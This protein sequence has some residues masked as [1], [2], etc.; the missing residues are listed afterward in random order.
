MIPLSLSSFYSLNPPQDLFSPL[1]D[2]LKNICA[3]FL[4]KSDLCRL[5]ETCKKNMTS[6]FSYHLDLSDRMQIEGRL[7]TILARTFNLRSIDFTCAS[8]NSTTDAE[9]LA[10]K[11]AESPELTSLDLSYCTGMQT[12]MIT[13]AQGLEHCPELRSIN[14]EGRDLEE[15]GISALV[16]QVQWESVTELK[17]GWEQNDLPRPLF[18][19]LAEALSRCHDLQ[20]LAFK[21][22]GFNDE[23]MALLKTHLQWKSLRSIVMSNSDGR[24]TPASTAILAECL[25]LSTKLES[26]TFLQDEEEEYLVTLPLYQNIH[27]ASIEAIELDADLSNEELDFL[28]QFIPNGATVTFGDCFGQCS[29]P[30]AAQFFAILHSRCTV[31]L[32]LHQTVLRVTTQT[33]KEVPWREIKTAEA[34]SLIMVLIQAK[35]ISNEHKKFS[36]IITTLTSSA[37]LSEL[38]TLDFSGDDRFNSSV[39]HELFAL[40]SKC[41][42]LETIDFSHTALDDQDLNQLI[43]AIPPLALKTMNMKNCP[44]ITDLGHFLIQEALERAC[45]SEVR[46]KEVDEPDQA[47]KRQ[48]K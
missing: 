43:P 23:E 25:N 28:G 18:Q 24:M 15:E 8:T 36:D 6:V 41:T 19:S 20:H 35:K 47:L 5:Q 45:Q 9:A 44:N 10:E 12:G 16:A 4:T 14:L 46:R 3:E 30:K 40:I 48:K 1:N 7:H 17:I 38:R 42:K 34:K 33:L 27:W 32:N 13:L 26:F 39:I 29:P 2:D 37:N 31:R 22:N 11:I 21:D